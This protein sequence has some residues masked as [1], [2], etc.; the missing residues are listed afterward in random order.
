MKKLE[1]VLV[2]DALLKPS[3]HLRSMAAD[4]TLTFKFDDEGNPEIWLGNRLWEVSGLGLTGAGELI[5]PGSPG[6]VVRVM[7]LED[8][9]Y[10]VALLSSPAA[11]PHH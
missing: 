1:P 5:D 6:P 7:A 9:A 3:A 11:M 2:G 10:I 8:Q 4:D